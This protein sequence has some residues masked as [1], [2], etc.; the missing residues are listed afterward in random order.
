M[1]ESS[2]TIHIRA[3]DKPFVA[4][5]ATTYASDAPS[6]RQV[7][8]VMKRTRD[9]VTVSTT[10]TGSGSFARVGDVDLIIQAPA[11]ADLDLSSHAGSIIVRGSRASVK[12]RMWAG[13]IDVRMAHVGGTQ[14][15]ALSATTGQ[16]TLRIP[17]GSSATVNALA[18]IGSNTNDFRT[19]TIGSGAAAIS[20]RVITGE[21]TLESGG[22][23]A[24]R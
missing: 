10:H 16:I 20:M 5:D 18:M 11:N 9:S 22:S 6:L 13:E 19:S 8:I 1:S 23:G 15:I 24:K 14:Q 4:V 3:W 2:G 12:A 17:P 21:V 7:R